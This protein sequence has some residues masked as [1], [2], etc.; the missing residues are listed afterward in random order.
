NAQGVAL[1]V[2]A[3]NGSTTY[4]GVIS[5]I[6]AASRI[7]KGGN[8]VFAMNAANTFTG[9]VTVSAGTVTT[10]NATGF[11]TSAT[12]TLVLGDVG[13]ATGNKNVTVLATGAVT[14]ANPVLVTSAA[15]AGTGTA[16]LGVSGVNATFS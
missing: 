13:T 5:G 4:T 11:G 3:N 8:G 1:T 6:N 9:G 2:G 14:V 12:A 16:T 7:T 10:N 15:V